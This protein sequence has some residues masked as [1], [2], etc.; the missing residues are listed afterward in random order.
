LSSRQSA[1]T[2]QDATPPTEPVENANL[3]PSQLLDLL[4]WHI[5]RYDRLRASTSTRASI[6]LSA[7]SVLL[8]GMILL[9]NYRLQQRQ[10][11]P[12]GP[13]DIAV[14]AVLLLT[15]ALS[16]GS[17]TNCVNAIAA[18]KTTRSLHKDEIPNRFLFNW[19]DTRR[20]VDGYTSFAAQVTA[21]DVDAIVGHA[22]AELWTDIL[23]H[24][25][26]H[27]YLRT[28]INLFR[29]GIVSFLTFAALTLLVV[30]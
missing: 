26:R 16:L 27:K 8:T 3:D 30:A 10:E 13:I 17:I 9:V 4:R 21:L 5:D 7:S 23:Q 19:G 6:L 29:Y 1:E 20:A 11:H 15:I 12:I 18:R 24:G 2:G 28:G 22:T 14:L 25:R